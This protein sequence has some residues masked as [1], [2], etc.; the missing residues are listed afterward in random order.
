MRKILVFLVL[1]MGC[2]PSQIAQWK[3]WY[4]KDPVAATEFANRPEI[5]AQ[6]SSDGP[7]FSDYISNER[8]WDRIARCESGGNWSYPPVTNRTGTYSG[9][10]MIWQKAWIAYGGQRYA[11]WAYQAT[12]AQQIIIAEKILADR[13]WRAWDCA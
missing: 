11:S 4:D 2:T 8:T 13:G 10:L 5:Q 9:G 1:L 12:K 3:D 6:L 7:Q